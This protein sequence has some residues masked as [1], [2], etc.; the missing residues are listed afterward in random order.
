[1]NLNI[2]NLEFMKFITIFNFT[3]LLICC[4]IFHSCNGDIRYIPPISGPDKDAVASFSSE[5]AVEWNK[6]FLEIETY[7][8]GYRPGP[9]SRALGF[10]GLA[11]YE[12]CVTGM[13]DFQSIKNLYGS[14]L[15]IPLIQ[16]GKSYYWP[17]VVHAVYGTL[18]PKF[19]PNVNT[20]LKTR[21]EALIL[22]L[23]EKYRTEVSEEVFNRSRDY[24]TNVGLA[25]W[26]WS[27]LDFA[28]GED[29]IKY[30]AYL[31][32]ID[33]F[34]GYDWT[35]HTGLGKWV[36]TLPG[37]GKPIGPIFGRFKTFAITEQSKLCLP[38]SYYGMVYSELPTSNYYAQA[39]ETY[40]KNAK[41][42]YLVKWI[43]EFWSD[44][45]LNLT[46]SH[47]PRWISIANQIIE[48]EKVNLETAIYVYS[49]V[50]FAL[51]DAVV[52]CWNSKYF[53]NI[54]R[55][56]TYIRKVIDPNYVPNLNNPISLEVGIVPSY[57]SYPS[58]HATLASASA[59]VLAS[60]FGY[61]YAMT[62]KSHE[63]RVDFIGT[64]RT[65][66]SLSDMALE[67]GWSRVLLGTNWS[68]DYY[69]GLRFGKSIGRQ[70]NELPW[71]K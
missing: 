6:L 31:N 45:L 67:S 12:A 51:N 56:V 3:L 33:P 62:D 20:S 26:N 16:N 23:N 70:V 47:G 29:F 21:M 34:Q 49:K 71:K 44:D 25:V 32:Y 18:I 36:P 1:M 27:I 63:S 54:E 24:G 65:F 53:Y 55:P 30:Y 61:N 28:V 7:A 13:P 69:E 38:P 40:S 2:Y 58:G 4:I 19:F 59:E 41:T 14:G 43:G 9:A 10:I 60:I 48:L 8:D 52:A 22:S 37:P 11:C 39:L 42:D 17:E 68:M 15:N 46:F 35:N 5:V 50:G 57:P 66:L 64:P